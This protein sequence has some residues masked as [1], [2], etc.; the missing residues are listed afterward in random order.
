MNRPCGQYFLVAS[1]LTAAVAVPRFCTAT[2]IPAPRDSRNISPTPSQIH[3]ITINNDGGPY[4]SRVYFGTLN[5]TN[6]DLII[7]PLPATESSALAMLAK[8]TDMIR[9]GYAFGDWTGTGITSS[10]AAA[11]AAGT[12][13]TSLGFPAPGITAVGV[14]L[15]DDGSMVN[16]DGSGFPIWNTW[17]GIAVDQYSVLVKYTFYGD[18][19]L[20]GYVDDNDVATVAAN[21]G[22]GMGWSQGEFQY[23]GGTV[24]TSDLTL[25]TKSRSLEAE[26]GVRV[27]VVPEPATF[28]LTIFPVGGLIVRVLTASGRRTIDH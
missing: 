5:L 6:N 25:V 15:N 20:K 9:S 19:T 17:D 12:G 27:P 4:G 1:I 26:Y 14:I 16:P 23:T 8:V 7:K 28:I 3:D 24:D 11:D 21:V 10:I 13:T 22:T 2:T 18:T